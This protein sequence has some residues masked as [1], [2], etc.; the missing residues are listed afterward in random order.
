V[1]D[2]RFFVKTTQAKSQN[3]NRAEART[4]VVKDDSDDVQVNAG[5]N[6]PLR[7]SYGQPDVHVLVSA[8]YHAT[9]HLIPPE[10]GLQAATVDATAISDGNRR[11]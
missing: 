2:T 8:M 6:W 1:S 7:L 3:I 10:L 4:D 9:L 5:H 11:R